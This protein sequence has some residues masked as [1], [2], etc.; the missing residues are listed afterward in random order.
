MSRLETVGILKPGISLATHKILRL[1]LFLLLIVLLVCILLG[2][3]Q[4]HSTFMFF[5]ALGLTFSYF[6]F[7]SLKAQDKTDIRSA[8]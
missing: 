7:M 3:N 1:V 6:W 2:I 8:D 4:P 5:L